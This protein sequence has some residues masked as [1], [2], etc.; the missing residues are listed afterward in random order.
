[1]SHRK[2]TSTKQAADPELIAHLQCLG[3]KTLGEYRQWCVE[4]GFRTSLRKRRFQRREELLYFRR[5]MA[6]NCLRQRKQ[7]QRSILDKLDAVCSVDA[8]IR[9]IPNPT[10]RNILKLYVVQRGRINRSG[11]VR[12]S[13]LKL[14]SQLYRHQSKLLAEDEAMYEWNNYATALVSIATKA[15]WWI[16]PVETWRPRGR[17]RRLQLASLLRH[18]FVKYQ[19]PLFFDSVWLTYSS[20]NYEICRDWY[21]DVGLGRNIR[22]CQLPIPYTKKMAHYFMQGPRDLTIFQALRW[23]QIRGLGGDIHQ[24]RAILSTR[25]AS[26]FSRDEFWTSVIH[27]LIHHSQL[28]RR[29][30][31]LLIDYFIFQRYGVSPE[32]YDDE[33]APVNEYCMK[34]RTVQSLI[35]DATEWYLDQENRKRTP[36]HVWEPSGL[37]EFDYRDEGPGDQSSKRWVIRELLNSYELDAE[38]N[39][40]NHCV[41]SYADSCVGGECSIWSMQIELQQGFK[42]A[43]TIEVRKENNLISE[44]RGKANRLP[45][46]RERNVLRRWAETAGLEFSRYVNV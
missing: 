18:L 21:L 10:L 9:S 33:S 24:A 20:P 45:N 17:N 31:R 28:D 34:G 11:I 25:L 19:M 43:I 39:Q 36:E 5:Q 32:E 27:W 13:F 38:G 23:G 6:V 26:G 2:G 22:H 35:R 46:P 16:R 8:E 12:T 14:I 15:R 29:Q 41:G 42:K 44:V 1:M 3:L 37:P 30:I 40:M 4:N 7:E